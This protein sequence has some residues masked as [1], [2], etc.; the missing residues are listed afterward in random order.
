MNNS[1]PRVV[2]AATPAH[3]SRRDFL[4]ATAGGALL[5]SMLHGASPAPNPE[6]TPAAMEPWAPHPKAAP[7]TGRRDGAFAID[8]NGTRT[9]T[10]GWQWRFDQIVP[11]ETYEISTDVRHYGVAVPRDAFNCTAIWGAPKA[12][13]TQ[14]GALWEYLL[15]EVS[16]ERL[17]FARRIVAPAGATRLTIRATLRWTAAGKSEWQL[18]RIVATTPMPANAPARISIV[19]GTHA[20]RRNRQFKSSAD[21][22][23]FYGKYCEDACRRDQP[24]L[25]VLPEVA[26]QWGVRGHPLDV[27][28]PANSAETAPFAALAR[29][30]GTRIALGMYERDGDAVYNSLVLFGPSGSLEGR[31]RKVHLAH[32]EDLSGVLPGDTFPVFSTELGRIGCNICM[33]SMAP[34]SARITALKGADLLLLPIMGDFRADRWN[35]GPPEFHEE[36]WRTIM[37]SQALDNQFSLAVAR[38]RSAGSCIVARNGDFL[39]WNDGTQPFITADVPRTDDFRSW[40]GSCFRDSAWQVRRPHLYGTFTDPANQG[41]S[42]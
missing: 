25:I 42:I 13:Q 4:L 9:C 35:I 28:A 23:E 1:H 40:N 33:D 32:G 22:V 16:G 27:A 20:E 3:L 17:R 10:G 37:R 11:G 5:P 24:A 39:A 14:P 30:H 15:P 18:P 26:L 6:L 34:E 38:N 41:G 19:T 12:G 21:N 31:Y 2:Q 7:L 29:Q 36:R 8:A